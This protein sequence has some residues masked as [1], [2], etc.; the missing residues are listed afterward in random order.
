MSSNA[1]E[2]V[3]AVLAGMFLGVLFGALVNRQIW[4][5]YRELRTALKEGRGPRNA[6]RSITRFLFVTTQ[7]CAIVWVSWTYIISTY[8]TVV[9][10]QAFPADAL[11]SEAVR[12]ILGVGIMKV[13]ENIFEH[14]DGFLF[15]RHKTENSPPDESGGEEGGGVG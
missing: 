4:K 13:V 5:R 11:S 6:I 15:G 7:I 3:A 8:A 10:E 14:N 1:L 9:L 2:I 12:T